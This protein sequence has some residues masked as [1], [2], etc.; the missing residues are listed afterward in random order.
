[1]NTAK[2]YIEK[3]K[4][5]LH[6]KKV[7]GVGDPFVPNSVIISPSELD[8]LLGDSIALTCQIKSLTQYS[9]LLTYACHVPE[10][11]ISQ[12]ISG[13][14]DSCVDGLEWFKPLCGIYT[15]TPQDKA[16]ITEM[17]RVWKSISKTRTN[18]SDQEL[19]FA[20]LQE[21]PNFDSDLMHFFLNDQTLY[22]YDVHVGSVLLRLYPERDVFLEE[23]YKW[24][25][26]GLTIPL[27]LACDNMPDILHWV[28][29]ELAKESS[30]VSFSSLIDAMNHADSPDEVK[31]ILMKLSDQDMNETSG[32][33]I[34]QLLDRVAILMRVKSN[35]WETYNLDRCLQSFPDLHTADVPDIWSNIKNAIECSFP[36]S[37]LAT[38]ITRPPMDTWGYPSLTYQVTGDGMTLRFSENKLKWIPVR[39]YSCQCMNPDLQFSKGFQ[40]ATPYRLQSVLQKVGEIVLGNEITHVMMFPMQ[41]SK[42]VSRFPPELQTDYNTL[43]ARKSF[44][45]SVMDNEENLSI[46][47]EGVLEFIQRFHDTQKAIPKH[48][49]KFRAPHQVLAWKLETPTRVVV[50][51]ETQEAADMNVDELIPH[52]IQK[53]VLDEKSPIKGCCHI[54]VTEGVD[55]NNIRESLLFFYNNNLI[56]SNTQ[57]ALQKKSAMTPLSAHV[58]EEAIVCFIKEPPKVNT[59]ELE[60]NQSTPWEKDQI[61]SRSLFHDII[62]PPCRFS[63]IL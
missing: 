17:I 52:K 41:A 22:G 38:P 46:N 55:V 36:P 61:D 10:S 26:R 43:C 2:T 28:P 53:V 57:P 27:M 3:L 21:L 47:K 4:K 59:S 54:H 18:M 24:R 49:T 34:A 9:R 37:L 50:Y 7:K 14:P 19:S 30:A 51:N 63:F 12:F 60:L 6:S 32:Q 31:G 33:I 62:F 11:P 44:M 5:H 1:M 25:S 39:R 29:A 15:I 40:P 42:Y 23:F 58:V 13:H 8:S 45:L 48:H 56:P 16:R 35:G 20:L